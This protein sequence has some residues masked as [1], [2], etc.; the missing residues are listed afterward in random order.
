[1][2]CTIWNVTSHWVHMLS[3]WVQGLEISYTLV[4]CM[5]KYSLDVPVPESATRNICYSGKVLFQEL[6]LFRLLNVYIK[7]LYQLSIYV[8]WNYMWGLHYMENR[9][10]C[11]DLLH[12]TNYC[13]YECNHWPP[14]PRNNVVLA[15]LCCLPLLCYSLQ[16]Q[17]KNINVQIHLPIPLGTTVVKMVLQGCKAQ[18]IIFN[19]TQTNYSV[20]LPKFS[21]C[22]VNHW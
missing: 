21:L 4:R 2:D 1:M 9:K 20:Q 16:R 11:Q 18:W 10:G 13:S 8:T 17:P 12:K 6:T 14:P 22:V 19:D 7:K 5:R 15:S 3:M